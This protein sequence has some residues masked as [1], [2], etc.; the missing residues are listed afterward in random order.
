M[1]ATAGPLTAGS[2]AGERV[3][4]A[5][6]LVA[7]FAAL[8]GIYWDV[9]WHATIGRDSFWI[10]P[11]LFVYAGVNVLLLSGLGG[12][13]LVWRRV[14][15]LRA[16]LADGV[17]AGFAVA[18]LGPIVQIAAAPLDDLWHVRY[19]LDVTIWS[20]PHLM[21]IAGG[22]VGIYGLLAALGA[23]GFPP[24]ARNAG[25]VWRRVSAPEVVALGLFGAALSLS[26]FALG[27]LDFHLEGRD[28]LFYP[29][30]A[31]TLAAVPL[32]GAARYFGRPGAATT[33]ALAYV[34]FRSSMLLV[35]WGMGSVEHLTPPVMVLAPALAID[36]V[37]WRAGR[38]YGGARVFGA[39]LLVGPALLAGEWGLRALLGFGGWEP[40]EVLAS[41]AVVAVAVAAGALAGDRLGSLLRPEGES[42]AHSADG[43]LDGDARRQPRLSRAFAPGRRHS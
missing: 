13:V 43:V 6:G 8:G 18:A 19:G 9:T 35:V 4:A 40:L 26:M 14:G 27:E 39:A 31:G 5:L 41:M 2:G 15:G 37:L 21:G 25:P 1:I 23:L 3:L 10:P 38:N 32:M 22:M 34:L 24:W 11:H 16:A 36:L 29:L 33:V 30:L 17:G 42:P 28:A 20:P 12:I 7:I